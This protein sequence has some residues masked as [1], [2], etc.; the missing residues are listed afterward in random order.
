MAQD[1]EKNYDK[2]FIDALCSILVK[3]QSLKNRDAQSLEDA[4]KN[5]SALYFE[6]FLLEEDFVSKEA[7]LQA[8]HEYYQFPAID[9]IGEFFD[10]HL[11]TMFPKDV[12]LR[13]AFIPYNRDGDILLVVAARPSH[14]E[15]PEIIGEFVSYDVTFMVG[16]YRDI[17]DQVK[18]FYDS[19]IEVADI[20][21]FEDTRDEHEMHPI[22]DILNKE[23]E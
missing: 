11:V 6:D 21:L 8:L 14:P 18:E 23:E 15:L 5:N 22:D 20:E 17:C 7:L 19:S 2:P 4:F 12:M 9:V 3:N 10:H 13:N 16:L 1:H